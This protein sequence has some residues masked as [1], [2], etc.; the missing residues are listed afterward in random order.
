MV[1]IVII[2]AI[3]ITL[4]LLAKF[5]GLDVLI[6]GFLAIVGFIGSLM[7]SVLVIAALCLVGLIFIPIVIIILICIFISELFGKD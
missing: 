2:L 1:N 3:L 7:L 5:G 4:V 6:N